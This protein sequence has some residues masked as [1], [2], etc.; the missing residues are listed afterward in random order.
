MC[1]VPTTTHVTQKRTGHL[2][3]P[4][5]FLCCRCCEGRCSG[6]LESRERRL[7]GELTYYFEHRM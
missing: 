1:Q 7:S 3:L 5:W 4:A 2:W 6:G